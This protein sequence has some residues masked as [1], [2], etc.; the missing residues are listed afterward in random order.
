MYKSIAAVHNIIFLIDVSTIFIFSNSSW[1]FNIILNV[2]IGK[3]A[4]ENFYALFRKI[5]Y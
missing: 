3:A 2:E 1:V 4:A 5:L